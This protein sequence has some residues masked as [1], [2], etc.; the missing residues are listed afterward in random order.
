MGKSTKNSDS[1]L[2]G[3]VPHEPKTVNVESG[4]PVTTTVVETVHDEDVPSHCTAVPVE[5]C[6]DIGQPKSTTTEHSAVA[7]EEQPVMHEANP[8]TAGSLSVQVDFSDGVMHGCWTFHEFLSSPDVSDLECVEED[9]RCM[10]N[11]TRKEILVTSHLQRQLRTIGQESRADELEVRSAA[12][13]GQLAWEE[14][15]YKTAC[16]LQLQRAEP[17]M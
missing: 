4:C 10:C 5:S 16:T 6:V 12:L 14:I 11:I 15:R 8:V 2:E 9:L 17:Q 13:E 7:Q 1:V 3:V